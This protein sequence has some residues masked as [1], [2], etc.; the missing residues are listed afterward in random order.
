MYLNC[1]SRKFYPDR[2]TLECYRRSHRSRE[3]RPNRYEFDMYHSKG[4]RGVRRDRKW[5]RYRER[6]ARR[7]VR[8]PSSS[9]ASPVWRGG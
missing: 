1:W 8:M 4:N 5:S 6:M 2:I 7:H 9:Q 3:H